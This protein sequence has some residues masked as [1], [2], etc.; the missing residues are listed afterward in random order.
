MIV[1]P[2]AASPHATHSFHGVVSGGVPS[3]LLHAQWPAHIT[4]VAC[5]VAGGCAC[6][7]TW[8]LVRC[9]CAVTRWLAK[10][11]MGAC[12]IACGMARHAASITMAWG[13]RYYMGPRNVCMQYYVTPWNVCMLY[14][15]G[16]YIG[17]GGG[18]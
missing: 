12:N 18:M 4:S 6:D 8:P 16:P 9:A 2:H 5:A 13:M 7:V 1:S 10:V 17:V 11:C 3:G 14:S 15:K